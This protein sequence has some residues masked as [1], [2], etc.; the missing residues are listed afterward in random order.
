MGGFGAVASFASAFGG[1]G[2]GESPGS[3]V[4]NEQPAPAYNGTINRTTVDIAVSK[5]IGS[6]KVPTPA[7][8]LDSTAATN[9]I[10][11]AYAQSLLSNT[12]SSSLTS[13]LTAVAAANGPLEPLTQEQLQIQALGARLNNG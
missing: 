4:S 9:K 3:L 2:S 10:D 7:F 12:Q 13:Q 1:G 8:G 6:S 11:I 5:I